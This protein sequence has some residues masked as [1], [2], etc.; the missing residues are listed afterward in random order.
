MPT[1]PRGVLCELFSKFLAKNPSQKRLFN[2]HK[3]VSKDQHRGKIYLL[4]FI[5]NNNLIEIKRQL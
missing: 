1:G 2:M 4:L 5:K 3:K